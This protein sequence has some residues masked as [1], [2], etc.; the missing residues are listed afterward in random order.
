M[1][2]KEAPSP[3]EVRL[4]TL[5]ATELYQGLISDGIWYT[6][7]KFNFNKLVTQYHSKGAAANMVQYYEQNNSINY[8]SCT[9]MSKI[10][11][12]SNDT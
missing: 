1:K 9:N 4:A 11:F 3:H 7:L 12:G 10:V 5:D 6:K 8:M 2:A